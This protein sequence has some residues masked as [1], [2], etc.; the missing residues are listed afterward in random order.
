[1]E[2]TDWK[3]MADVA[4]GQLNI[5]TCEP[6]TPAWRADGFVALRVYYGTKKLR[7]QK[8]EIIISLELREY[9]PNIS[10]W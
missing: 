5:G 6:Y 3:L 4:G 2:V 8:I 9:E 7:G 1:M 10:S